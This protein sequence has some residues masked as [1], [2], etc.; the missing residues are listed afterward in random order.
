MCVRGGTDYSPMTMP[1]RPSVLALCGALVALLL[2]A[3]P[4][5]AVAG[6]AEAP[7]LWPPKD[8]PGSLFVHFGEEH[9]NDADGAKLLPN[10]VRT[11]ARFRPDLVT[12]SG[13]KA[14]NGKDD[15]F[16]LWLDVMRI[17]DRKGIP[18]FAGVG[19]HDRTTPPGVP[20]GT[21]PLASFDAYAEFFRDRPYP[22]GD[23]GG[24]RARTISPRRRPAGDPDGA[25]S[26][27]FVDSGPVRWVFIDNSCF[28]I[29]VCDL[30]QNPSAQNLSSESQYDFM[31]R[32]GGEA[33]Q[34]GKLVFVVMHMPTQD[35][36][37][38]LTADPTSVT[39]TMGKGPLGI[40]DNT[41]F[42][43]TAVAAG[44]DGVFV[45][46]IKGQWLYEGQG[47]I[48]YF[49]DG[50]AGGELYTNGP[51][52]IDHGYWH[53]FRL[54]RVKAG[55]LTTDVVPI[56]VPDGIRITGSRELKVGARRT[57][58]AFG[59][60]PVFND[61]AKV[62]ALELRDPDPTP[63]F[64]GDQELSI[65]PIA[66]WLG[67]TLVLFLVVS[68]RTASGASRRRR[69]AVPA[70]AAVAALGVGGVSIAQ[71]SEPTSTPVE[72]LPNLA[73]IWTSSNPQVLKPVASPS[74]DAR[75]N[76]RT[77]TADGSFRARCPGRVRLWVTSGSQRASKRVVV[78]G[79]GGPQCRS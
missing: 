36:R 54:I 78:T 31:E 43:Q 34:Q 65:P 8:L 59:R 72:A 19:N 73:R 57:F 2:L 58:E 32:V 26:H 56:F 27:Y 77:Q 47:G 35:P 41:L 61:P 60:Q 40:L 16:T 25:S 5:A 70:L 45:G 62:P 39:H 1:A 33:S 68:A 64:G 20:G 66:L 11:S 63:R 49:I 12:M 17:Y 21:F 42:E 48:P 24:Y 44:V 14:N 15:E 52:G 69:L 10:I 9:I 4:S 53:G 6:P 50:G 37:D 18:W 55:R 23:A 71:Q 76:R 79:R 28:S 75:R 3:A 51:V 67:P 30:I 29:V 13:D 7:K 38:Q 74:D 46:H 22:M